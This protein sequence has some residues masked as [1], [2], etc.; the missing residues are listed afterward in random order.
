MSIVEAPTAT[1]NVLVVDD[2]ARARQSIVDVLEMLGHRGSACSGGHEALQR[3]DAGEFDAVVTDL[4]MPGMDGLELVQQIRRRDA[5]IPIVMVTAHG[6]VSTAVEAMRFGAADYLEKPLNADRLEA[7]INRVL[8]NAASGDRATVTA[9]DDDSEVAMIGDSRAMEIVRQ[10]IAQVAPTDE[11]VLIIGESG[12]GKELV[13]RTIHQWSRRAGRALISLNCPVLSAHLMESE[14]FG[15]TRGAFTSADSSRVGRFELAEQ[16]TILL[17]EISEIDL[18]LQAKLLRVLQE[19]CYERVGSSETVDADVRVLATTNRDLPGEVSA[20][21][22]RRDLYYRLAVVPIELPPLRQR[23]DDIPLLVN[24][25]LQQTAVRLE[26]PMCDVQ[27]AALDLLVRHDWPGNVRELENIVTRSCVLATDGQVTANALSAWLHGE[28][29]EE[30]SDS[31]EAPVGVKLDE[32][33]RRLISATLEHYDGHR[34]KTA[35]A[36]GISPRTLS[37]KLRSYGLAPRA[38][39]FARAI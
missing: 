32:M 17:D 38:K 4:Q 13:A 33:E 6:S 10:R 2:N 1:G 31:V 34:E 22:F 28:A 15:H 25:F 3:M 39:T 16:G 8:E 12:V 18:S 35:A 19:R 5:H 23:R 14:L 21:R 9:P 24:H 37:N 11:T 29:S 27:P 20:G 26:R 36:L 7:V 30:A